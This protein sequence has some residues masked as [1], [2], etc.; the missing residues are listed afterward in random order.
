MVVSTCPLLPLPDGHVY[1]CPFSAVVPLT[2]SEVRVPTLVRLEAV[3]PLA[4]VLPV[5]VPAAAVTVPLLPS[6]IAVPFTVTLLFASAELAIAVK[7]D[8][9]VPEVSVPTLVRLDETTE[10]FSVVPVSV[11]A[12]AVTVMFAVPS[13]LVPLIVRAV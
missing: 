5:R 6:A 11:P 1:V 7:P 3:T 8:P 10:L 9:I 4:R 12:A 2:A 13:K